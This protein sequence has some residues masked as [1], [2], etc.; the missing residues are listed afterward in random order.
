MSR[1]VPSLG[2]PPQD[3]SLLRGGP[4]FQPDDVLVRI[5][6]AKHE[7]PWYFD[8][9]GDGRFNLVG[10]ADG[11]C[12]TASD[13]VGATREVLGHDFQEGD[14][15]PPDF[16][17]VRVAWLLEPEL[18]QWSEIVDL[19]DDCWQRVQLTQELWACHTYE[20]PQAWAL[21]FRSAGHAGMRTGLRHSLSADRFGVALFGPA[22]AQ[23]SDW[24]F[25]EC[26]RNE[27]TESMVSEFV[28]ATGIV[29][30]PTPIDSGEFQIIA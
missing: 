4:A 16:F 27:I 25:V 8:N 5:C 26:E 13:F 19:R 12:Y 11:T 3:P 29:V 2:R 30:A 17:A 7:A 24:R 9:S 23:T 22:G 1:Q 14:P 10:T 20:L 15:I 21:A 28:Q 6:G 18:S